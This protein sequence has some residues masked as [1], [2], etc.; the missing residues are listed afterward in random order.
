MTCVFM[1][2]RRRELKQKHRR[3]AH[4]KMEADIG[5]MQLQVKEH[6]ATGSW[7]RQGKILP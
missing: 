3:E 4:I 6:G 7:E 1:R 5:V 2:E